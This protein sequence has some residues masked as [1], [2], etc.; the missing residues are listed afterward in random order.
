MYHVKLKEFISIYPQFNDYISDIIRCAGNYGMNERMTTLASI[1]RILYSINSTTLKV[2]TMKLKIFLIA[3]SQKMLTDVGDFDSAQCGIF[4]LRNEFVSAVNLYDGL[5]MLVISE[6]KNPLDPSDFIHRIRCSIMCMFYMYP[7]RKQNIITDIVI[8]VIKKR[9]AGKDFVAWALM[10]VDNP[11]YL[12]SV[13]H[14]I[15]IITQVNHENEKIMAYILT[16]FVNSSSAKTFRDIINLIHDIHV[17]TNIAKTDIQPP[18][19]KHGIDEVS[20]IIKLRLSVVNPDEINSMD[21]KTLNEWFDVYEKYSAMES[22]HG[23][24]SISFEKSIKALKL[25]DAIKY[26]SDIFEY[27]DSN[28]GLAISPIIPAISSGLNSFKN[29]VQELMKCIKDEYSDNHDG[30]GIQSVKILSI[31]NDKDICLEYIHIQIYKSLINDTKKFRYMDLV[32]DISSI[33]GSGIS[34][35]KSMIEE[36][37]RCI[38]TSSKFKNYLKSHFRNSCVDTNFK[39]NFS[40]IKHALIPKINI[41]ECDL[42]ESI[43]LMY[44]RFLEFS[45]I[46]EEKKITLCGNLSTVV[47]REIKSDAKITCTMGYHLILDKFVGEGEV[48]IEKNKYLDKLVSCGI[49]KLVLTRECKLE[50]SH[51]ESQNQIQHLYMISNDLD[52]DTKFNLSEPTH[53]REKINKST[54][55]DR[56]MIIQSI[57]VKIMKLNKKS[58]IPELFALVKKNKTF[59]ISYDSFM[60]ELKNLNIGEYVELNGNDVTYIA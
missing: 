20:K 10:Y 44:A 56:K 29:V 57:I 13:S 7:E 40:I 18:I 45:E 17:I 3:N 21:L 55:M 41:V 16:E 22:L 11:I 54:D 4:R 19:W 23:M 26:I 48:V 15:S 38:E 34:K 52:S 46:S 30:H 36:H 47:L 39:V 8:P 51:V 27:F 60:I 14:L 59:A 53:S 31:I 33:Y 28:R 6:L 5:F 49:L 1:Y 58:T 25:R 9:L 24:L 2:N 42:T 37:S 35:I 32:D 50:T 43:N 12:K